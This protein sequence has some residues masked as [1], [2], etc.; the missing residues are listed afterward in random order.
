MS[1]MSQLLKVCVVDFA[2]LHIARE[3]VKV[4]SNP[5]WRVRA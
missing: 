1:E 2:Q 3:S 5:R 4:P